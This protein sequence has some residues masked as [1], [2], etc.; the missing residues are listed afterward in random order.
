[1]RDGLGS[2]KRE[3]LIFGSRR[4]M[5]TWEAP[6]SKKKKKSFENV[7]KLSRR[8]KNLWY[9][10]E[11]LRNETRSLAHLSIA[12]SSSVVDVAFYVLLWSCILFRDNVF[13]MDYVIFQECHAFY[14]ET[15]YYVSFCTMYYVFCELCFHML[16]CHKWFYVY[17]FFYFMSCISFRNK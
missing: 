5:P 8:V 6:N 9:V 4:C 12:L 14:L 17:E 7:K 1:V 2:Y 10:N 15:I 13:V 16:Q 3:N 11:S